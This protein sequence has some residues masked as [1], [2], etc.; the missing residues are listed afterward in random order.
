MAEEAGSGGSYG[1]EAR[2]WEDRGPV[3]VGTIVAT[4]LAAGVIAFLIRRSREEQPPAS[5]LA[6]FAR[7]FV[8]SDTA[9]LGREFF[10]DKLLPELKPSLLSMLG[11]LED[12]VEQA[13]RRAEKGIRKL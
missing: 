6:R 5:R 7:E 2:P 1:S 10:S 4:A 13:F 12:V 3:A 11:E 9:D 8:D